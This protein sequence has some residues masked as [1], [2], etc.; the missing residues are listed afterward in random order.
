[1][2]SEDGGVGNQDHE[3]TKD[4]VTLPN[5][6]YFTLYMVRTY[7]KFHARK[8]RNHLFQESFFEEKI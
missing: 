4:H 7:N 5:S 3:S 6:I 2:G 8:G 1:V